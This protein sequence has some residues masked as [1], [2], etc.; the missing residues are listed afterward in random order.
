MRSVIPLA[1]IVGLVVASPTPLS[2]STRATPYDLTI[3]S[4]NDATYSGKHPECG[5]I[6]EPGCGPL[7][8]GGSG[9]L[10]G[11]AGSGVL[12]ASSG[13]NAAGLHIRRATVKRQGLLG[14]LDTNIIEDKL[15]GLTGGG[16][17]SSVG[18]LTGGGGLSG[19]TQPLGGLGLKRDILGG[20]RLLNF[21]RPGKTTPGFKGYQPNASVCVTGRRY[22]CKYLR[23]Y[24]DPRNAG[25]LDGALVQDGLLNDVSVG[26]VCETLTNA[27]AVGQCS[28]NAVCCTS[29]RRTDNGIINLGCTPL[30]L[31]A[32]I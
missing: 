25:L 7:H 26:L 29:Q 28:N 3:E 10:A 14:G 30:A 12:G 27:L 11:D 5:G 4:S 24:S 6:L 1:L 19:L 21:G 2:P 16:G 31:G 32:A 17:L 23:K 22:C 18:G 9:L 13:L 8:L 20:G 15:G